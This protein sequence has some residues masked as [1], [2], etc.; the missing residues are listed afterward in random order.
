MTDATTTGFT[1]CMHTLFDQ[2]QIA[3]NKAVDY[4][5]HLN[6]HNYAVCN[7]GSAVSEGDTAIYR[8]K[9]AE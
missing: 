6:Y 8:S 3:E 1:I 2:R 5:V 4:N 9:S 7:Q